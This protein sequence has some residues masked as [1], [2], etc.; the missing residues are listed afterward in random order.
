MSIDAVWVSAKQQVPG[1]HSLTIAL[2]LAI[3]HSILTDHCKLTTAAL[4]LHVTSQTLYLPQL[5]FFLKSR[6]FLKSRA[7]WPF[8][9]LI[10]TCALCKHHQLLRVVIAF[11]RVTGIIQFIPARLLALT[12][13]PTCSMLSAQ[14][15]AEFPIY[16]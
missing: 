15:V 7:P 9:D 12:T 14:Q 8:L 4:T 11:Y 5:G 2:C 6:T 10:S 3:I 16:T 13:F 1:T